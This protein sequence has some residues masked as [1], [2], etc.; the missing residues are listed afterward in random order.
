MVRLNQVNFGNPAKEGGR[1]WDEAAV[2]R[3][4]SELAAG[5]DGEV[6]RVDIH[7]EV[8]PETKSE[9][10]DPLPGEGGDPF[11]RAGEGLLGDLPV[12]EVAD[13]ARVPREDGVDG[14]RGRGGGGGVPEEADARG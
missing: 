8:L 10:L 3:E 6:K 12:A 1:G 11:V 5:E 14:G 13:G 4:V 7:T 2:E 9:G